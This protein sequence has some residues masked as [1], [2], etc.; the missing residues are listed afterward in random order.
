MRDIKRGVCPKSGRLGIRARDLKRDVCFKTDR[1]GMRVRDV[2]RDLCAP[3]TCIH[4]QQLPETL[5]D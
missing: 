4:H 3:H 5:K 2:K 1:L